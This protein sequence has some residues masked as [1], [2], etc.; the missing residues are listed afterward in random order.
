M[1]IFKINN[2][3]LEPISEKK[4]DLER[5]I[6]KLTEQ[7][8]ETIFGLK[9][10][11][12]SLNQEFSARVNEQDFY[13]DTLAFNESDKSIVLIEYKKDKSFSVIDQ[14]FA[15]LAAMSNNKGD[16]VLEINKRLNKNFGRDD[17]CWENSRVYFVSRDF[18]NYQI[19]AINFRDLPME[20]YQVQWLEGVIDFRQIKPA[21]TSDSINK[22]VK[23]TNIQKVLK[24]VKV[25]SKEDIIKLA[26]NETRELFDNLEEQ[27][28]SINQS[29]KVNVTKLYTAYKLQ[30]NGQWY[31]FTELIPQASGI[32][33]HLDIPKGQLDDPKN[34]VIDCSDLNHWATG[35]SKIRIENLEDIDYTVK[36]IKQTYDKVIEDDNISWHKG[37][38]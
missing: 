37:S 26:W 4:I 20:L 38:R 15:Y 10:V 18:T 33:V 11:S 21:K 31:N 6:Q 36:L 22:Y 28:V 3:K 24:E 32:V 14:G 13:I 27:I 25:Y 19:N 34:L 1:P 16:F 2:Q 35:R 8:L 7:N 17:I 12:G 30:K 9:F 5:D 29:I 23:D